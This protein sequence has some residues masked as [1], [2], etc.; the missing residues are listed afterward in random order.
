[1]L[2]YAGIAECIK[3]LL[4]LP[5]PVLYEKHG[6]FVAHCKLTVIIRR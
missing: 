5:Y 4:L 2:T 1:M 6:E 3:R